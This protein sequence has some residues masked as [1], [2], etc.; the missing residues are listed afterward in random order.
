MDARTSIVGGSGEYAR[1]PTDVAFALTGLGGSNAFGAG[2]LQA[3][4]DHGITPRIVTCTSGMIY[5][6]WR[7][8]EA[9][10][11]NARDPQPGRLRR[12]VEAMIAKAE[13]FPKSLGGLNAWLMAT[14]AVPDV[15]RWAHREYVARFFTTPLFGTDAIYPDA[16]LDLIFPAQLM[17]PTRSPQTFADMAAAFTA[18]PE[19]GICFNSFLAETGTEY[20]HA[21]T[22]ARTLLSAE[23]ERMVR[24][25]A[26]R[27]STAATRPRRR[28]LTRKVVDGITAQDIEDAL[29]LT[30]Y[31]AHSNVGRGGYADRLDGAYVRSVILS[32]LTMVD[33]VLMPRPV[34]TQR[35]DFPSNYFE[36][37]DFKTELWWN[38]SCSPQV[39]A[40]EFVNTLARDGCTVTVKDRDSGEARTLAF[41]EV[42]VVPIEIDVDRGYFA[43]FREDLAT[44]DRGYNEAR[45]AFD[46][47]EKGGGSGQA[48]TAAAGPAEAATVL[49]ELEPRELR[50]AAA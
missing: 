46:R 35:K 30:L 38:A 3:A 10:R 25:K 45:I 48:A 28:T 43:Y 6:T 21:N 9:R 20:L 47:L 49:G 1:R 36:V 16:W 39:A 15:F 32:E 8:L 7:W 37:E 11:A 22:A 26:G 27:T 40:I 4:L 41:R 19:I 24:I 23:E 44:F 34:A 2:F 18:E 42:D 13:P 17:V 50:P 29:W 14:M 33:T 31:G 5:W 12:E